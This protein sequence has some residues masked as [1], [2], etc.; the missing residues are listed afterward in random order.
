M[1]WEKKLKENLFKFIKNFEH[2]FIWG[3]LILKVVYPSPPRIGEGAAPG[4]LPLGWM[5]GAYVE[6]R[7]PMA[8]GPVAYDRP[9]P[10]N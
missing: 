1:N 7:A 5:Q 3:K 10:F 2:F 9:I 4:L 6:W 8:Y